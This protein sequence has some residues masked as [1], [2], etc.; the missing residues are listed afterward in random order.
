MNVSGKK[1][2]LVA[3]LLDSVQNKTS[4]STVDNKTNDNSSKWIL[5][6]Q[7]S[8]PIPM[9]QNHMKYTNPSGNVNENC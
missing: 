7:A 2:N 8:I 3:W 6:P 9:L 4:T 5:L 1:A